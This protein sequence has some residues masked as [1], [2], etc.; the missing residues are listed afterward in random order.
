MAK[1]IPNVFAR[2]LGGSVGN[3]TFIRNPYGTLVRDRVM[4]RDPHTAAQA[5]TRSRMARVGSLW[6]SMTP[7]QAAAWNLYAQE[8][9]MEGGVEAL[10]RTT[11][12]QQVFTR[13]A[14]KVLQV[15]ETASV[16][17]APPTSPFAGDSPILVAEGSATAVRFSASAANAPGVVTE[18]LLQRLA[19]P[20]RR[21][22]TERFRSQRFHAFTS[23]GDVVEVSVAPGIYAAACRFVRAATG[24]CTGLMLLGRV[25]V[26]ANSR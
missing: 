20:H 14:L 7:E 5:G 9:A 2:A 4:P 6:R 26:G 19:S 18:V 22:Y 16:P 12:G 17:L 21:L 24:Q 15:D 3:V 25:S 10:E 23:G 13:L 8:T 1:L 11:T